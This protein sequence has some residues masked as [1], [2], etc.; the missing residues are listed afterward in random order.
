MKPNKSSIRTLLFASAH[1]PV[2]A[3]VLC[4]AAGCTHTMK[5]SVKPAT[6]P[7]VAKSPAK[8]A[9]VLGKDFTEYKHEMHMMGDT[10]L[11]PL[12]APL[13]DYASN[14]T[15][16]CFS[17]VTAYSTPTEAAG[18]ADAILTPKVTKIDESYG[19][20]AASKHNMVMV[21][22][23]TLRDRDN[24]KELWLESLDARAE[25]KMGNLFSYKKQH[26]QLMQSLFDDLSLKTQKA[27]TESPQLKQL[28]KPAAP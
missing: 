1:A 14:V 8:I 27:F 2:L 24:Q 16:H 18:K 5:T 22:Q 21:M 9:L 23:W 20:W 15:K 12:G 25:A 13:Q 28:G 3:A 26:L 11:S 10:F 19:I 7:A 4:L 17:E 6:L